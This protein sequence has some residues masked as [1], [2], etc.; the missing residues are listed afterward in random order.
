[1]VTTRRYALRASQLSRIQKHHLQLPEIVGLTELIP[2]T[3]CT[4]EEAYASGAILVAGTISE[5]ESTRWLPA[6]AR[7]DAAMLAKQ[8][9][10][11]RRVLI[12]YARLGLHPGEDGTWRYRSRLPVGQMSAKFEVCA[13]GNTE[14]PKAQVL[15]SILRKSRSRVRAEAQQF[16]PVVD[17][18]VASFERLTSRYPEFERSAAEKVLQ[19]ILSTRNRKISDIETAMLR[20]TGR[21]LQNVERGRAISQLAEAHAELHISCVRAEHGNTIFCL[22]LL[23]PGQKPR[24]TF[25]A[26]KQAAS[27]IVAQFIRAHRWRLEGLPL[28]V[29]ADNELHGLLATVD[30]IKLGPLLPPDDELCLEAAQRYRAYWEAN[31]P[32]KLRCRNGAH[33]VKQ[34]RPRDVAVFTDASKLCSASG[35]ASVLMGPTV[36]HPVVVSARTEPASTT[37]LEARAVVMGLETLET[38]AP[39]SQAKVFTDNKGVAEA[40][41]FYRDT[42]LLTPLIRSAMGNR[43]PEWVLDMLE[44]HQVNWVKGHAGIQGNVLADKA[45]LQARMSSGPAWA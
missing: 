29:R 17:S 28:V 4:V 15:Y 34:P 32:K 8:L 41:S 36:R 39:T 10:K 35:I 5:P 26:R 21:F 37:V 19:S 43:R 9:E 18:C 6:T 38:Y 11:E 3:D 44:R 22:R 2:G 25:R 12:Q 13:P 1:M 27:H 7:R 16:Q 45:A 24:I 23:V 40:F 30:E 33:P 42:G 31:V 20:Y 14:H